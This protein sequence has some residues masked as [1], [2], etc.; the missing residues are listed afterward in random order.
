MGPPLLGGLGYID[1]LADLSNPG[2]TAPGGAAAPEQG[3]R[4]LHH[5]LGGGHGGHGRSGEQRRGAA[6]RIYHIE[7]V[8]IALGRGALNRA[9]CTREAGGED[10]GLLQLAKPPSITALSKGALDGGSKG[11]IQD[12]MT[13]H[14]PVLLSSIK[15]HF[16]LKNPTD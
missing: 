14:E 1:R 4:R 8:E 10:H 7:R 9:D 3:R 13:Y 2:A 5:R 6:H 16:S 15:E 11:P 12:I